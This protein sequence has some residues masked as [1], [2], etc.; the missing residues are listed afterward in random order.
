[1]KVGRA[2]LLGHGEDLKDIRIFGRI[3]HREAPLA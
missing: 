1:M 2:G 3:A